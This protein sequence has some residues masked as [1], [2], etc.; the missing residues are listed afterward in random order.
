M[1][2]KAA[3]APVPPTD[4]E[5]SQS[6]PNQKL[7]TKL[8][9]FKNDPQLKQTILAEARMHHESDQLTRGIYGRETPKGWRGCAVGCAIHSLN[10]RTGKNYKLGDHSVCGGDYIRKQARR[11]FG[12]GIASRFFN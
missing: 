10:L 5:R 2:N 7:K 12:R 8:N 1:K 4:A 6:T 11:Q 3:Q 9:T